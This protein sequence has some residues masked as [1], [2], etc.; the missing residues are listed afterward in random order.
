MR[1]RESGL[2]GQTAA[3]KPRLKETKK[4]ERTAQASKHKKWT[5]DQWE[6]VLCSEEESKFMVPTNVSL[7]DTEKVKGWWIPT[8]KEEGCLTTMASGGVLQQVL[9]LADMVWDELHCRVKKKRE[10]VRGEEQR[11]PAFF[12]SCVFLVVIVNICV[13]LHF[14]RDIYQIW[15]KR[16]LFSSICFIPLFPSSFQSRLLPSLDK[17]PCSLHDLRIKC[18]IKAKRDRREKDSK[19]PGEDRTETLF[20]QPQV[21][22]G[23]CQPSPE[24]LFLFVK[25]VF[26]PELSPSSRPCGSYPLHQPPVLNPAK[27]KQASIIQRNLLISAPGVVIFILVCSC[28]TSPDDLQK[29]LGCIK[30]GSYGGDDSQGSQQERV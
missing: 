4:K 3:K 28:I 11:K 9:H 29:G 22:R 10:S 18:E 26:S 1:R 25:S 27:I 5:L 2:H 17:S 20:P 8:A 15:E 6:Y 14:S 30:L 7:R 12:T 16:S 23:S 24:L 13:F 21:T 19:G